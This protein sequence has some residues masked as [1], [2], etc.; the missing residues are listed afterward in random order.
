VRRLRRS[1]P[2]VASF[3]FSRLGVPDSSAASP[4]MVDSTL[5]PA[6]AYAW[7]VLLPPRPE[8]RRS[9]DRQALPKLRCDRTSDA[10]EVDVTGRVFRA[11]CLVRLAR[12]HFTYGGFSPRG[13]KRLAS[14]H[15]PLP[16]P[17]PG[18]S[19]D[20]AA[21]AELFPDSP[22]TFR[23][24]SLLGEK[25][26]IGQSPS[27]SPSKKEPAAWPLRTVSLPGLT[28]LV[29]VGTQVDPAIA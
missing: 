10:A 13:R 18:V 7:M 25:S 28:I 14:R 3:A 29:S 16:D 23:S 17:F 20:S 21:S 19:G 22:Q 5:A 24:P 15:H 2:P 26:G 6:P 1:S 11:S 12:S 8:D 4:V 27:R 9:L